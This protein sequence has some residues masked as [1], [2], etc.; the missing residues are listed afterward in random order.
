MLRIVTTGK[1]LSQTFSFLPDG[2]ATDC[3]LQFLLSRHAIVLLAW[4]MYSILSDRQFSVHWYTH[5][6]MFA[7]WVHVHIYI[8]NF[9]CQALTFCELY[10]YT[11]QN[12]YFY[13][14]V[15]FFL[16]SFFKLV[17][18]KIYDLIFLNMH[19]IFPLFSKS[20]T[21]WSE[22]CSVICI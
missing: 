22:F 2:S 16:F 15:L 1:K 3:T 13:R 17:Q 9:F 8:I 21:Q 10:V 5:K 20:N 18:H 12:A 11:F 14:T 6:Q 19:L 7:V 4:T